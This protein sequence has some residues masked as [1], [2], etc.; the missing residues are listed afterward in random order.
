M[1]DKR[2]Y[3]AVAAVAVLGVILGSFLP[4]VRF[5]GPFGQFTK[6]GLEDDSDGIITL[7]L[8]AVAVWGVASY[9]F[10]R[11]SGLAQS[12]LLTALGVGVIAVASFDLADTHGRAAGVLK[13]FEAL[14]TEGAP[15]GEE[16]PFD[17]VAAEGLYMVLIA[18]ITLFL[19][20][21]AALTLPQQV[22][23]TRDELPIEA[24][25]PTS[26]P[27]ESPQEET[28]STDS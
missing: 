7:A 17:F 12:L 19:A 24:P 14:A 11:G 8:G 5:T 21:L 4:W 13:E 9:Y 2:V 20:G 18:G 27:A 10:E 26:P 6:I 28:P 22:S 23:P 1:R 16:F 25:P 15:P 3:A